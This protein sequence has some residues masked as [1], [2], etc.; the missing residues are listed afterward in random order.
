MSNTPHEIPEEFPEYREQIHG[1]KLSDAHFARL[2]DDYHEINREVH[3]A[4]TNVA[5]TDDLHMAEMRK[6]RLALKDEIFALLLKA[7]EGRG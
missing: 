3:R 7:A 6:K 5:P 1:L 4:E 2:L